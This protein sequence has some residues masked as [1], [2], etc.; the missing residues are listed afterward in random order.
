MGAIVDFL[1]LGPEELVLVKN[2]Y[3]NSLATNQTNSAQII[4]L[5]RVIIPNEDDD[6]YY[7]FLVDNQIAMSS[8]NFYSRIKS[9]QK[10]VKRMKARIAMAIG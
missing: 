9:D 2:K 8:K 10:F 3:P 5:Y 4:Q 1:L 6:S 7:H